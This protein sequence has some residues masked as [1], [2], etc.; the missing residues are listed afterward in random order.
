MTNGFKFSQARYDLLGIGGIEWCESRALSR[1]FSEYAFA[2]TCSR[3]RLALK[4]IWGK[5]LLQMGQRR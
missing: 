4:V 5:E 1:Y 3:S 2:M